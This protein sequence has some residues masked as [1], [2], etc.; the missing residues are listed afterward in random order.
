M[1]SKNRNLPESLPV[2][3]TIDGKEHKGSYYVEGGCVTARYGDQRKTTQLG[4]HVTYPE[5]LAR[6]LLRE[7]VSEV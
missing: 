5:G 2:S 1:A 7:M 4:G 3:V 6:Q